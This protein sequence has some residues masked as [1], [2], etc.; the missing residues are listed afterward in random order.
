[1]HRS[2]FPRTGW[3]VVRIL[4]DRIDRSDEIPSTAQVIDAL[5]FGAGSRMTYVIEGS[6]GVASIKKLNRMIDNG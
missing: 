5:V 6:V 2:F 4:V 1:M 3:I